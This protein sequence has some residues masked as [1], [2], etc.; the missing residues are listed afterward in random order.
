METSSAIQ[1]TLGTVLLS[2]VMK[3]S[4]KGLVSLSEMIKDVEMRTYNWSDTY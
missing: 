3:Y 1:E 2:G 4:P